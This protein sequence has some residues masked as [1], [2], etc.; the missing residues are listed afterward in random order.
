[1]LSIVLDNLSVF[2]EWLRQA[3]VVAWGLAFVVLPFAMVG[4]AVRG[5]SAVP[6][7]DTVRRAV[8]RAS[9][10]LQNQLYD[11]VAYP[12]M[13]KLV[14]YGDVCVS[15]SLSAVLYLFFVAIALLAGASQLGW[16]PRR[17]SFFED[18]EVLA[19]CFACALFGAILKAQGGRALQTLRANG[20]SIQVLPAEIGKLV[21][22][23]I[24]AHQRLF[25]EPFLDV[26]PVFRDEQRPRSQQLAS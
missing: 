18:I 16:T 20:D 7:I 3:I 1:M 26:A 22:L 11:P 24:L 14:D 23:Q 5:W 21:N 15:F 13:E 4:K 6:L 9:C 25:G 17:P 12:R 8:Q 10:W 19:F 2:P